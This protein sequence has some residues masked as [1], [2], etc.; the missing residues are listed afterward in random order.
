M[1]HGTFSQALRE[2]TNA[3]KLKT[4]PVCRG[5]RIISDMS[6]H[7]QLI[8]QLILYVPLEGNIP[9]AHIYRKEQIFTFSRGML[10]LATFL[11]FPF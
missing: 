3:A 11:D 4:V 9:Q 6:K 1:E 2:N 5:E 7:K 8:K 10:V